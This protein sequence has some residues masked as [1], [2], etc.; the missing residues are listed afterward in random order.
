[1]EAHRKEMKARLDSVDKL[2]QTVAML[3]ETLQET[4]KELTVS[5]AAGKD[6]KA[7]QEKV[8]RQRDELTAMDSS[9]KTL[10]KSVQRAS[11]RLAELRPAAEVCIAVRVACCC[12]SHQNPSVLFTHS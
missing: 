8:D 5:K 12:H 2:S 4:K 3:S 1:M 9:K 11:E 7:L 6:R 10:E